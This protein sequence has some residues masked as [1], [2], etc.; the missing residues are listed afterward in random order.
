MVIIKKL[1]KNNINKCPICKNKILKTE[2]YF[3]FCSKNCADIDL[4]R[5][6]SGRYFFSDDN[7][8]KN[9]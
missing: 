2:N 3:P 1:H 9:D 6:F 8:I 4:S 7:K 5:W